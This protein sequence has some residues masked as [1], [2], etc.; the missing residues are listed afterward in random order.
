MTELTDDERRIL[1]AF[2]RGDEH[3]PGAEPEAPP[4]G[5]DWQPPIPQY[6]YP[7]DGSDV[8]D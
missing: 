5:A 4:P 7:E 3:I 6:I 8:A 2:E 1:A